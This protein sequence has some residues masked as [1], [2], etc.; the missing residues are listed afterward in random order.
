MVTSLAAKPR[1]TV[2]QT[3]QALPLGLPETA[4]VVTDD[5]PIPQCY[6]A[7]ARR[8]QLLALQQAEKAVLTIDF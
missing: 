5:E 1:Q 6:D 7:Q 8:Q 2:R 3:S 4:R